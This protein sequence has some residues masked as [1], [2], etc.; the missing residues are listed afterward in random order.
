MHFTGRT[1]PFGLLL[2]CCLGHAGRAQRPGESTLAARVAERIRAVPGAEVAVSYR[3][4]ATGDSIDIGADVDYHAAS[5]M[6][7]PV[8]LE[9]VR[10]AEQT[11]A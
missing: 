2:L 7:I 1:L 5:T 4:L 8:M 9:V 6:K 10:A 11:N 3:D